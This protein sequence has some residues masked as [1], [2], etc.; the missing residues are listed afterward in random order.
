MID[1]LHS[2]SSKEEVQESFVEN[3]DNIRNSTLKW[4]ENHGR[5][6]MKTLTQEQEKEFQ[7]A[8]TCWFCGK[9]ISL[10]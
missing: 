5:V 10:K 3:M 2:S 1:I 6:K 9:G 8:T 7:N 4:L